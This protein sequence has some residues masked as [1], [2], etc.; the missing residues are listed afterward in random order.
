MQSAKG[1]QLSFTY[2]NCQN[3]TETITA[4][5]QSANYL[6]K[7]RLDACTQLVCTA[8]M[9]GFKLAPTDSRVAHG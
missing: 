3:T 6:L 2:G 4:D 1:L 7:R 5:P 8:C 9:Q